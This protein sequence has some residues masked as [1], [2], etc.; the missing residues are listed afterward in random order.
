MY[1]Y[2]F[3]LRTEELAAFGSMDELP[4]RLSDLEEMHRQRRE[5]VNV[6]GLGS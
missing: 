1:G 5:Y 4:K 2:F 3:L 6:G